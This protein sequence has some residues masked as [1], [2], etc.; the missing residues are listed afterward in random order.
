MTYESDSS[1]S[2]TVKSQDTLIFFLPTEGH[3]TLSNV[4]SNL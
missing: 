3:Y 4:R 2:Y 1:I